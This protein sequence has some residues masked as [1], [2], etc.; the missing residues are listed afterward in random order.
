MPEGPEIRRAADGLAEALCH[1]PLTTLWFHTAALNRRAKALRDQ[2][3]VAVRPW[4]KAL[5][6]E[7]ESGWQIYSHNQLY[8]RWMVVPSGT[9]PETKRSLRVVLENDEAAALLY[10]ASDIS[11]LAPGEWQTHP[12]LSRLG[13]DIFHPKTT[14]ALLRR[15]LGSSRFA[16]R[17]LGALLMHQPFLAGL[18]NYLRSEILYAARLHPAMRAGDLDRDG[19]GRLSRAMTQLAERAYRTHGETAPKSWVR[20][21]LR[22]GEGWQQA[23]H[24]VFE[25]EGLPCPSCE[26]PVTRIPFDGRRLYLCTLCQEAPA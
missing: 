22:L 10:S 26:A 7:F 5:L 20:A 9:R 16:R 25:R 3:I 12:F 1:R 6:T 4:G 23:R 8:G 14:P 24:W 18:G 15:R 21:R 17:P 13:P 11:V 2:T 19:A